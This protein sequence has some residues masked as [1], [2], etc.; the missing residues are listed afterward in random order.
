MLLAQSVNR[1]LVHRNQLI[2]RALFHS[3]LKN[4]AVL[5]SNME[6]LDAQDR[7]GFS[8]N[9][10][11][12]ISF[13]VVQSQ[14]SS[15]FS[16]SFMSDQSSQGGQQQLENYESLGSLSLNA[17]TQTNVPLPFSPS[18]EKENSPRMNMPENCTDQQI[19]FTSSDLQETLYPGSSQCVQQGTMKIRVD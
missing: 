15:M 13:G 9:R 2:L 5:P 12:D 8:A 16:G 18:A 4:G 19:K 17:V 6:E 14:T 10:F 11:K 7:M 1:N 3:S